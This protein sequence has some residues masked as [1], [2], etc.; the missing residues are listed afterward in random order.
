ML[1]LY[2]INTEANILRSCK[3]MTR[4]EVVHR[5]YLER[6]LILGSDLGYKCF[7]NILK[8]SKHESELFSCLIDCH[9]QLP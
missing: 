1:V 8:L 6:M 5:N 7:L 9:I 2:I 3:G 4:T